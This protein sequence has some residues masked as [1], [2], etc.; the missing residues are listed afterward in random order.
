MPLPARQRKAPDDGDFERVAN[1]LHPAQFELPRP[2]Q[3]D[4]SGD[5]RAHLKAEL[6]NYLNYHLTYV[7]P[8]TDD[9]ALYE[10]D[11]QSPLTD[12]IQRLT[13]G[14]IEAVEC[15]YRGRLLQADEAFRAALNFVD[16][17]N[18]TSIETI[19]AHHSFYRA[20]PEGT[21]RFTKRDLFH[22]PF[23]SRGLVGTNRYSIPGLPALY[24]GDS[25][26]VCWEELNKPRL[27]SLNFSRFENVR[28]LK[29]VKL[30]R[31]TD[32]LPQ[33]RAVVPNLHN[34]YT[35]LLRY[36]ALFPL[37]ITCCIKTKSTTDTFKPEY[38]IPQLLLQYVT[39][40]KETMSGIMYPSTKADYG[41]ARGVLLYNY[42][43]PVKDI[44]GS[45]HCSDLAAAFALTEPTSIDVESMASYGNVRPFTLDEC[46][47]MDSNPQTLALVVDDPRD[48]LMTGF[49]FIERTLRK[50]NPKL[51]TP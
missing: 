38:V 5:F 26:Y 46:N 39:S 2:A 49:G 41:I 51:L 20:R 31:L 37:S 1:Q 32:Y 27:H 8:H 36:L 43:F 6:D 4:A 50:R 16:F 40:E 23:E 47:E 21:K 34:R 19:R 15:Y 22:H 10:G 7:K 25:T 35:Y 30:Q 14:I 3:S 28:D 45:G 12:K 11:E 29:V 13:E 42:V 24:L 9:V 18:L 33:L 17:N 48:Y 44:Q